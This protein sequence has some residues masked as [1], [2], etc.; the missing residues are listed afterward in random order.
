M[1]GAWIPNPTWRANG[2]LSLLVVLVGLS[3][4]FGWWG[5]LSLA[6]A[7]AAVVLAAFIVASSY[8]RRLMADLALF[9]AAEE[10]L[11]PASSRALAVG[12]HPPS[13][14]AV[15]SNEGSRHLPPFRIEPLG[16]RRGRPHST[17]SRTDLVSHRDARG[18]DLLPGEK[19]GTRPGLLMGL[20][21][22][23][24][25][26]SYSFAMPLPVLE[27][28][29]WR[30]GP[31]GAWAYDPFGL[32][33]QMVA[34]L[35][36]CRVVV[37]PQTVY[38]TPVPGAAGAPI[39]APRS[40]LV[41]AEPAQS[42][43]E[44]IGLRE[45]RSGDR[46]SLIVTRSLRRHGKLL[47]REFSSERD[48]VLSIVVDDRAGVHRRSEFEE[49]CSA[50]L[51]VVAAELAEGEVIRLLTLSGQPAPLILSPAMTA[52]SRP[53]AM[54]RQTIAARRA[55]ASRQ[56]PTSGLP[57][58]SRQPPV[59]GAQHLHAARTWIAALTARD[60]DPLHGLPAQGFQ[61]REIVV[62]TPG[63]EASLVTMGTGETLSMT[64]VTC[65]AG[66]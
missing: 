3:D 65:L 57:P 12:G 63:A 66:Q 38:D 39:P 20:Y 40:R 46:L 44:Y 23:R 16:S 19:I 25:H 64:K 58:A 8:S 11:L 27:R 24:P 1:R 13:L 33:G 31:L 37:Y 18:S 47:V 15:A 17:W 7:I 56:P 60:C 6:G 2:L 32:F 22:L 9:P 14:M 62:T 26:G 48:S 10:L 51:A 49:M 50:L 61:R 55:A 41:M 21:A 30:A 29:V 36:S 43:G 5:L 59:P 28:G 34:V 45:Y 35:P 4:A 52:M 54:P 42:V 53:A